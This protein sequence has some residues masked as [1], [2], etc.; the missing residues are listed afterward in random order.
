MTF[1]EGSIDGEILK[2]SDGKQ[3]NITRPAGK[4]LIS[5]DSTHFAEITQDSSSRLV[6]LKVTDDKTIETHAFTYDGTSVRIATY[7]HGVAGV[8]AEDIQFHYDSKGRLSYQINGD[9]TATRFVRD[10]QKRTV[11]TVYHDGTILEEKFD[12][13]GKLVSSKHYVLGKDATPLSEK[14]YEYSTAQVVK[15]IVMPRGRTEIEYDTA[16]PTMPISSKTFVGTTLMSQ[17]E[18]VRDPNTW[19][20]TVTRQK[21]PSDQ[22][23]SETFVQWTTQW[24]Y[25]PVAIENSVERTC[26]QY[27]Y[28]GNQTTISYFEAVPARTATNASSPACSAGAGTKMNEEVYDRRNLVKQIDPNAP[29][30]QSVTSFTYGSSDTLTDV[31]SAGKNT[32]FGY[33]SWGRLTSSTDPDGTFSTFSYNASGEIESKT[34]QY[35]TGA[36][37][38]ETYSRQFHE[39]GSISLLTKT[40][41][42]PNAQQEVYE[43]RYANRASGGKLEKA[44]K[45]GV[46]L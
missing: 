45:N 16:D 12:A 37:Q 31:V 4:L 35:P 2:Y 19:L 40:V 3:L 46:E 5:R 42:L 11:E 29:A 32:K 24:P 8:P 20:S 6:E 21:G 41:V 23:E 10:F 44:L 7:R 30:A 25:L 13:A 17:T 39:D 18:S 27:V 28:S 38:S 36:Q 1:F 43:L 22:I 15:K 26:S 9:G 34:V 33:D 14:S